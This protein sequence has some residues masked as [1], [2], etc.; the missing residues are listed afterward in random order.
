MAETAGAGAGAGA[1]PTWSDRL[2]EKGHGRWAAENGGQVDPVQQQPRLLRQGSL[3]WEQSVSQGPP[4][5]SE[6]LPEEGP[7]GLR[8][9]PSQEGHARPKTLKHSGTSWWPALSPTG[10]DLEASQG[11]A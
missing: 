11:R 1:G 10:K 4:P 8:C 3:G 5:W 6:D 2:E 9:S 7:P